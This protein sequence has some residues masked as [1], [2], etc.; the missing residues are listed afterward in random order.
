MRPETYTWL[1]T[2][3]A[4]F[5]SSAPMASMFGPSVA[6]APVPESLEI[7]TRSRGSARTWRPWIRGMLGSQCY[8]VTATGLMGLDIIR[9]LDRRHSFVYT[10]WTQPAFTHL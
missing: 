1:T 3:R 2:S 9:L 6:A 5:E 7:C 8:R 4:R 10:R